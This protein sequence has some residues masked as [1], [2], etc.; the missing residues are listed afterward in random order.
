MI[1]NRDKRLLCYALTHPGMIPTM[2]SFGTGFKRAIKKSY[3]R[4]D[5]LASPPVVV[6]I[7]PTYRCN[8]KCIMCNI[9]KEHGIQLSGSGSTDLG[10]ELSLENFKTFI[11]EIAWFRPHI[12]FSGGEPLLRRDIFELI[13]FSSAKIF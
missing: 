12:H 6:V 3:L 10:N 5:N 13:K 11:S 2:W 4:Q 1:K 8:S 9:W 7:R